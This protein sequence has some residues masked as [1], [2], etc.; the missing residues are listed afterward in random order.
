LSIRLGEQFLGGVANTPCFRQRQPG[1]P[2]VVAPL[3]MTHDALFGST[4]NP[5]RRPGARLCLNTLITHL[6]GE[7]FTPIL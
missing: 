1:L 2:L 6:T 4:D 3:D 7:G 5:T